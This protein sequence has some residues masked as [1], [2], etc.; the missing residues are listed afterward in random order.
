MYIYIYIYVFI[1]IYTY[2]YI[3]SCNT[4]RICSRAA[5]MHEHDAHSEGAA[6]TYT[7]SVFYSSPQSVR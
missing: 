1:Y 3:C 2:V 5:A 6:T 7:T 4:A